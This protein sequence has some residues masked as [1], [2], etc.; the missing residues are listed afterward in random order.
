ML[1]VARPSGIGSLF[2]RI[3]RCFRNVG[4][5]APQQVS[6]TSSLCTSRLILLRIIGRRKE[7][8]SGRSA[9]SRAHARPHAHTRSLSPDLDKKRSGIY[10]QMCILSV[11]ES[12]QS[13]EGRRRESRLRRISPRWRYL[14]ARWSATT[15]HPTCKSPL[16]VRV[17]SRRDTTSVS[18]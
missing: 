1:S 6:A 8:S 3:R 18:S 5:A 2:L 12:K 11:E 15:S 17:R 10:L 9:L 14:A 13:R 4:C 7:E 16:D